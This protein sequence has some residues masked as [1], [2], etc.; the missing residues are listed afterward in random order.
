MATGK[1][2]DE[3]ATLFEPDPYV[4]KLLPL[5]KKDFSNNPIGNDFGLV[6]V[7]CWPAD[8]D[9]QRAYNDFIA[10]IERIFDPADL[11]SNA[12]YFYPPMS[13]HITVATLHGILSPMSGCSRETLTQFWTS[14]VGDA[15]RRPSW[16]K[17]T[18]KIRISSAQIGNMAGILIWE[19][20]T[21]GLIDD[22]RRCIGEETLS[23]K[24]EAEALGIDI[25][26]LF[27]PSIIHTSFLRFQIV[28]VTNGVAV[29]EKFWQVLPKLGQL[30]PQTLALNYVTLVCERIP[31]MHIP[32]DYHHVLKEIHFG[33]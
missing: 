18:V 24:Q 21:D 13:L 33:H 16:P 15:S 23:R 12:V 9:L 4:L 31:C 2:R 7:T 3:P 1:P 19:E 25:R 11:I 26:T 29:Q 28:P 30:F 8:S 10:R 6:L 32:K 22:M 17:S 5:D 20:V 14:V 27:L